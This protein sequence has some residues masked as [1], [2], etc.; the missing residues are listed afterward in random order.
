[1]G[2]SSVKLE[3]ALEDIQELYIDTA[4]FI[5]FVEQYPAYVDK[6]RLIFHYVHSGTITAVTSVITLTETLPKPIREKDIQL[7]TNYQQLFLN[8]YN[9]RLVPV[10]TVQPE[11]TGRAAN[12]H[13]SRSRLRSILTN[14]LTI[15][16]IQEIKVLVLDE[17]E[18]S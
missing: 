6:M 9:L 5:Y 4:P 13:S 11:N 14:D 17:L 15:K 1:M 7:E 16:R 10:G 18:L 3:D 8:T 12:C 2:S